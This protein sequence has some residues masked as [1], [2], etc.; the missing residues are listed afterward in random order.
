M[1]EHVIQLTFSKSTKGTHVYAAKDEAAVITGVYIKRTAMPATP[2][3][4]VELV[5]RHE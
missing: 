5:L 3:P 4:I 2:P 1:T